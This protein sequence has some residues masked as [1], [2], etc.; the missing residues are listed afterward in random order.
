MIKN[1]LIYIAVLAI[2]FL[3]AVFIMPGFP[4]FC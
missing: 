1:I 4:I 3:F 2:S